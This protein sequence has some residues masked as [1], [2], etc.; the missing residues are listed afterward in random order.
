[1]RDGGCT[2]AS[3]RTVPPRNDVARNKPRAY[4][5]ASTP[6][7][8]STA[9]FGRRRRRCAIP[10]PY[11]RRRGNSASPMAAGRTTRPARPSRDR[12]TPPA[13]DGTDALYG[14][15]KEKKKVKI[16]LSIALASV[17]ASK[18]R[19]RQLGVNVRNTFEGHAAMASRV[20]I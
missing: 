20:H 15:G 2:G 18:R 7:P 14:S 10:P 12:P 3:P 8:R 16:R 1:M 17:S 19:V 6:S 11:L 13:D 5:E 9:I 4:K